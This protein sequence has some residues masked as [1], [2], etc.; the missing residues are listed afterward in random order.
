[1]AGGLL[2]HLVL[3]ML[4]LL[5]HEHVAAWCDNTSTVSWARRMTS[6]RSR[7]G[8]RLVRALMMRINVNEASPLVTVSIQGC[9]NDMADVASRSFGPAGKASAATFASSNP[10]F[11][12][13]F[14]AQFPLD[15][16]DS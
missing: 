15:Q 2:Q 1:M 8:H 11:L 5:K 12:N 4:V 9:R 6:S 10:S 13:S 7:I 16:D 14:N 3:E